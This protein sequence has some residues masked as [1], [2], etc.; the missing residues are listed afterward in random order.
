MKVAIHQPEYWALPRLLAKWSQADLLVLLDTVQFD[1]ASLQHRAALTSG[2]GQLRW[3]TIPFHHE[4][5]VPKLRSLEP[6]DPRWPMQHLVRLGQW[7]FA[8]G[9]PQNRNEQ[10]AA[11]YKTMEKESEHSIAQYAIS[12]ML[13]MA[14]Q[15]GLMTPTVLASALFP[16]EGG[17][18]SKADLVLNICKVVGADCYLSGVTGATY[19]E[20]AG[21]Q[22]HDAGIAVE[23]Q[24]FPGARE[25]SKQGKELSSLHVYLTD[26]PEALHEVVHRR[27]H[28]S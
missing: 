12:T 27:Q 19:L 4:A 21:F 5:I 18:G 10:I 2:D 26:G 14:H 8:K 22:F 23:V 28:A 6:A 1:R 16:P 17:W 13:W 11:W 7:Y 9:T 20:R 3:L 15:I 25:Y 24:A